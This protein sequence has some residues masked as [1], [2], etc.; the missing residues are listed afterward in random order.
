MKEW[1]HAAYLYGT[2]IKKQV[3]VLKLKIAEMEEAM[4]N[5]TVIKGEEIETTSSGFSEDLVQE[6]QLVK[7]EA[8]TFLEKNWAPRLVRDAKL[9]LNMKLYSRACLYY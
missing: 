9:K 1:A 7:D 8:N 6:L 4:K 2:E 3:V 5:G